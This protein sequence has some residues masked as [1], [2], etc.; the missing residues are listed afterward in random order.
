M[1]I[2]FYLFIF[3]QFFNFLGGLAEK[4]KEE[5]SEPNSVKWEKV[6]AE[7]NN[8]IQMKKVIWKSYNND[9]IYFQGD[10]DKDIFSEKNEK[11]IH[12]NQ[13]KSPLDALSR[14]TQIESYIP[15]N[16]FLKEDSIDTTVQWKSS[17]SSGAGGGTGHQNL[18]VRFDYGLS[19]DSVL[20]FY[21]A[22]SDDPLFNFI[23]NEVFQIYHHFC[24]AQF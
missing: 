14:N 16:N 20:S 11:V 6:K 24:N 9:Q 21:A 13:T 4:V 5:S 17:F 8:P 12:N 15:L 10:N 1:R 22:E 18:S 19:K 23:N 7:E 3:I 2:I